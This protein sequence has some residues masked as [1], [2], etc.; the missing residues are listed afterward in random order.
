MGFILPL[1]GACVLY[2]ENSCSNLKMKCPERVI[3]SG[4]MVD[5]VEY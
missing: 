2:G 4:Y 1:P 5:V 3:G